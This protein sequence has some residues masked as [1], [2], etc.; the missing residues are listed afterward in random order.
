MSD[1][2][3]NELRQT[4]EASAHRKRG[5]SK[6]AATEDTLRALADR[7]DEITD[8][9]PG[10]TIPG[11]DLELVLADGVPLETQYH[12]LQINL[13]Q[14]LTHEV[15]VARSRSDYFSGGDM[16]IYYSPEQARFIAENPPSKY[17]KFTGPDYF[18]VDHVAHRDRPVWIA[19][20]EDWRYP[21]VIVE[22]LSRSTASIDRGI[23]KQRYQDIFR[24]PEYYMYKPGSG[25]FE[26]FHLHEGKYRPAERDAG[27]RVWSSSLGVWIGLWRGDYLGSTCTW[28]RFFDSSGESA[29]KMIPTSF[30]RAQA[31]E[32]EARAA[33]GRAQAAETEARAADGR[34]QA[35]KAEARAADGR[36]QAAKAEARAAEERARAAEERARAAEQE[37]ERVL[38]ELARIRA[39]MLDRSSED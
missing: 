23:K 5:Q 16:F 26:A 35:A 14:H 38:A 31:A 2:T 10:R 7:P 15:M 24:T 27:E 3:T 28:L 4:A 25:R 17:R 22:L 9:I 21:D 19:W 8:T 32:V 20:E 37:R 34:A 33:D 30:E 36:A 11:T 13:L 12:A 39:E 29:G 18:F 6:S 1:L